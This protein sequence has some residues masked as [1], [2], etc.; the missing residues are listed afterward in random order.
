MA[1]SPLEQPFIVIREVVAYS[2]FP[3]A[4]HCYIWIIVAYS[5]LEQ[6]FIVICEV[7]AYSPFSTDIFIVIY[8]CYMGLAYSP[9]EQPSYAK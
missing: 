7:V 5:P 6:P 2:P 3:T 4:I 8:D 1:Y 9:L